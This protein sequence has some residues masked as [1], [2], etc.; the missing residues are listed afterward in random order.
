MALQPPEHPWLSARSSIH[1]TPE[2]GT[3]SVEHIEETSYSVKLFACP[4][5]KRDPSDYAERQSCSK[6]GWTT[7]HGLR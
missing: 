2:D 3:E 1:T 7:I 6:S 5:L 4:Y